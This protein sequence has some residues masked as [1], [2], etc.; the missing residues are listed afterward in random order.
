MRTSQ[1]A[2]GLSTVKPT[3]RGSLFFN[4]KQI[5]SIVLLAVVDAKYNFLYSVVGSYGKDSDSLLFQNF[6]FN[7]KL[8][9][10]DLNI[11]KG[12]P[13]PG[14]DHPPCLMYL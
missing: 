6:T 5:F 12:K 4:Y 7:K 10:G 3:K 9:G 11:P 14:T 1:T 13:L 8:Q 2:Y